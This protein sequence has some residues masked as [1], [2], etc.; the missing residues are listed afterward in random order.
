MYSCMIH[1]EFYDIILLIHDVTGYIMY[2][3]RIRYVF[4]DI[5][6]FLLDVTG[7]IASPMTIPSRKSVP[8]DRSRGTF[9]YKNAKQYIITYLLN[10]ICRRAFSNKYAKQYMFTYLLNMICITLFVPK[11]HIEQHNLC[12]IYKPNIISMQSTYIAKKFAYMMQIKQ[13]NSHWRTQREGGQG[14]CLPPPFPNRKVKGPNN[15]SPPPTFE[16]Y[17]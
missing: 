1:H 6:W 7:Y 15:Y 16:V 3:C 5:I 13:C 17:I 9:S 10:M 2:S 11:K 14:P 12:P 8:G 4:Y